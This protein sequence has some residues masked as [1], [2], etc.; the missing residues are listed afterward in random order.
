MAQSRE[1]VGQ[2]DDEEVQMVLRQ[3]RS[4]MTKSL[5]LMALLSAIVIAVLAKWHQYA[6]VW[7]VALAVFIG[8]LILAF[9]TWLKWYYSVYI[10]TN[11]RIK[12]QRQVNLFKKSTVDVYL[13]KVEN[14]SYNISGLRGSLFGY[15]TIVLH[16]VAGDMVMTRIGHCE[17]VYS[18]LS[19]IVRSAGGTT[20]NDDE[21]QER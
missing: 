13:D 12:H 14:I 10:V 1:F 20:E 8:V 16:T 21:E 5:L 4:V 9:N 11:E 17:Q 18:E 15:G 6:V 19:A 7:Y 3:H 2:G